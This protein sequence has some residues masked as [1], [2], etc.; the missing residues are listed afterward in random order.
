MAGLST[1]RQWL[2]DF[3][4]RSKHERKKRQS[5]TETSNLP[6]DTRDVNDMNPDYQ[7]QVISEETEGNGESTEKAVEDVT[8]ITEEEG[9]QQPG[10]QQV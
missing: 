8:E 5:Q 7:E 3:G 6:S 10:N 2:R 9:E 1:V 4:R